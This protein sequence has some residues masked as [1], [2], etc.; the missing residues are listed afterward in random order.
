MKTENSMFCHRIYDGRNNYLS[1]IALYAPENLYYTYYTMA[2]KDCTDTAYN[3]YCEL[4]YECIDT[5]HCY[6]CSYG[7]RLRN[8][9]DCYFCEDCT[10]CSNC[11]GCKNLHQK[12]YCI[13]N[14]QKSKDEYQAFIGSCNF[15]SHAFVQQTLENSKQFF[16][17][18]PHRSNVM[19]DVENVTGGSVFHCR[20]S[21]ELYDWYESERMTY[22]ALG[23]KSHDCMDIYGMGVG[24]FCLDCVTNMYVHHLLFC[25]SSANSSDL[26]YCYESSTDTSDCF[27][28]ASMKKGKYCI[29]NKQYNKDEYERLAGRLVEHMQRTGE[30]GEFPPTQYSPLAYNESVAQDHYPLTRD[31]A[32]KKGY[33][34]HEADDDI[35]K[36]SNTITADRLPDATADIPDDIL[37]WAIECPVS[38]RLYKIIKQ[39]LA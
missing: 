32:E 15:G 5:E 38:H 22:C 27:G 31:T 35:G 11:Y 29:L 33:R 3:Q 9:R 16:L 28:C 10:G 19:I 8:C 30:W 7:L 36:V 37:N 20:D 21:R 2:C 25:I 23:E 17:K 39:V 6:Q 18:Y 14:E 12:Q 26:L 34:W 1:I 13:Y 24:D 4:C